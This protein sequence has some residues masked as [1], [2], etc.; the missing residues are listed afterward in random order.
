MMIRVRGIVICVNA[1]FTGYQYHDKNSTNLCPYE[2]M[3]NAVER[4]DMLWGGQKRG[5]MEGE[6]AGILL[7]FCQVNRI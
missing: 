6:E 5:M 3:H 2:S 4:F 1:V 7:C